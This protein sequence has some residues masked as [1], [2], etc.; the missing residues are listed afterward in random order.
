MRI[1]RVKIHWAGPPEMA[2]WK[3]L[4]VLAAIVFSLA[5]WAYV[6]TL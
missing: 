3:R 5:M 2:L 4:L 1:G 6:Y